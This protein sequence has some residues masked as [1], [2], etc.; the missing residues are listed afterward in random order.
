MAEFLLLTES[1]SMRNIKA[2]KKLCCLLRLESPSMSLAVDFSIT[3]FLVLCV[4]KSKEE[5]K[6]VGFF[7]SM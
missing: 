1:E 3:G 5:K 4:F 6:I 7:C 2:V